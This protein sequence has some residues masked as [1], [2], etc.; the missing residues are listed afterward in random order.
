MYL[1]I[2]GKLGGGPSLLVFIEQAIKHR[3][4]TNYMLFQPQIIFAISLLATYLTI[5]IA[6]LNPPLPP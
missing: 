3:F 2:H 4:K 6:P 1:I 5:G